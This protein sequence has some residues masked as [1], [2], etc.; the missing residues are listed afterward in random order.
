MLPPESIF[1]FS[2]NYFIKFRAGVAEEMG[3]EGGKAGGTDALILTDRGFA[4]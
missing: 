3:Y 2:L 4:R 1:E